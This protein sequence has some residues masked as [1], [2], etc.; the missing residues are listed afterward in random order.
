ML[1]LLLLP[2]SISLLALLMYQARVIALFF[3]LCSTKAEEEEE[4]EEYISY[5]MRQWRR[6][7]RRKVSDFNRRMNFAGNLCISR[8]ID[9]LSASFF[10]YPFSEN[11]GS[12][13]QI[14]SSPF[15]IHYFMSWVF[16]NS[17][18]SL[19]G[20]AWDAQKL[21]GVKRSLADGGSNMCYSTLFL[22]FSLFLSPPPL[23]LN[24]SILSLP[25]LFLPQRD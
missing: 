7:C 11:N 9:L 25:S 20:S 14:R 18:L 22:S 8:R 19:E 5:K 1:L 23:S 10:S 13:D 2:A 15:Y 6:R 4:E 21:R 24:L 16:F 12:N 3:V 17:T